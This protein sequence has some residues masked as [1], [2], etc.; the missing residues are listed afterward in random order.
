MG[1]LLLVTG[2]GGGGGGGGS[3][4][5]PP[6]GTVPITSVTAQDIATKGVNSSVQVSET[7]NQSTTPLQTPKSISKKL[8]GVASVAW[9]LFESVSG[10]Q[11]KSVGSRSIPN[12]AITCGSGSGV[13]S[14]TDANSS[15]SFDLGDTATMTYTSCVNHLGATLNGALSVSLTEYS[16]SHAKITVNFTNFSMTSGSDAVQISGDMTIA[17]DRSGST[18]T[19]SV[20]GTSLTMTSSAHGTSSMSNYSA[21]VTDTPSKASLDVRM[22]IQNDQL[23]GTIYVYTPSPLSDDKACGDPDGGSLRINGANGSYALLTPGTGSD[24]GKVVITGSD[25]TE[26]FTINTTW[27]AL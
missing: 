8:P 2:C 9:G 13:L 1:I 4:S 14:F 26:S 27:S 12:R 11:L 15:N 22:M 7:V 17:A 25:G 18:N 20:S 24:C 21:T 3:D 23:N 6:S 16:S 19:V 5:P 10:S